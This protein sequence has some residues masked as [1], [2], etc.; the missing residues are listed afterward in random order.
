MLRIGSVF[1][2]NIG[3]QI[4]LDFLLDHLLMYVNVWGLVWRHSTFF[5][6][7]LTLISVDFVDPSLS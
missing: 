5:I 4:S 2:N 6:N 1:V 3:T 7:H